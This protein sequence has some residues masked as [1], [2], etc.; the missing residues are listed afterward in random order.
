MKQIGAHDFESLSEAVG[1]TTAFGI[2]TLALAR[3][4]YYD[5]DI[6]LVVTAAVSIVGTCIF[7]Y[8]TVALG[9]YGDTSNDYAG[10]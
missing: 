3:G 9:L 4:A 1:I 8:N 7:T 2:M 10:T 6:Q 5:R